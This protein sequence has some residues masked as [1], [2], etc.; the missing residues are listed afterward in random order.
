MRVGISLWLGMRF[1]TR[2]LLMYF[3]LFFVVSCCVFTLFLTIGSYEYQVDRRFASKQPHLTLSQDSSDSQWQTL[4]STTEGDNLKAVLLQQDN[5]LAVSEFIKVRKWLHLNATTQQM[6]DVNSTTA[7]DKFS[8]G[9]VSIIGVERTIPTVVPLG[10]LNYYNAGM[11]KFKITNLEFVAD[12]LTNPE[13]VIPNAVLDA[14]FFPPIS[15]QVAIKSVSNSGTSTGQIKAFLNDYS[16]ESILYVGIDRMQTWLAEDDIKERGIYITL[17]DSRKLA[18]T[19]VILTGLLA[20]SRHAWLITSWL[21]EK[22]KQKTILFITQFISYSLMV[23]LVMMLLLML[24]LHQT[25]VLINKAKSLK[26]F[27]MTGYL[28]IYP[29]STLVATASL[30]G[31]LMAYLFAH[32]WIT[33]FILGLFGL[34]TAISGVFAW[35][36]ILCVVVMVNLASVLSMQNR[37]VY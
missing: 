22:N 1:F 26:I 13:L 11:Y 23:I 35:W 37:L 34:V 5:V 36:V 30:M 17:Q 33:P 21:D 10:G 2:P 19:R 27:F 32:Y 25:K 31:V 28:L 12:W 4:M 24:I 18:E 3:S 6:T 20:S 14:S 8:V 29:L 7:F 9:D 15:Q 16:D